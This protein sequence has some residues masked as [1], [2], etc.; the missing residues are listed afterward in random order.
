[1]NRHQAHTLNL[2]AQARQ[3]QK[4]A[5]AGMEDAAETS[6]RAML[7]NIFDH[8]SYEMVR[9]AAEAHAASQ[10]VA[11][12]AQTAK[13]LDLTDAQVAD[14]QAGAYFAPDED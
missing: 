1:M 7:N 5:L 3:A 8:A 14:A 4:M 2:I 11:T 10:Q 13:M 9:Y 12:L 6:R